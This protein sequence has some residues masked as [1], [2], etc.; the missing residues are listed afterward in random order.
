MSESQDVL[1]ANEAFY[2]A[3][4]EGDFA[5]MDGLWAVEA[6]VACIH[7]GWFTLTGRA[8]V[9]E[10][11]RAILG[12]PPPVLVSEAQAHVLG[13][14]AFVTCVET[15]AGTALVA[16]NIF[17]NENGAW[18]MVHHQAGHATRTLDVTPDASSSVH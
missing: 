4:T 18:R 1:A 7:P 15:V 9:I 13:A 17:A 12:N 10:S 5:A 3:F 16:T 6:L 8:V 11:W 14:S 2:R